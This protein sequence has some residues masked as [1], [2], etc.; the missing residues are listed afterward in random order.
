[1]QPVDER[2]QVEPRERRRAP[3]AAALHR[4]GRG[5]DGD[6]AEIDRVRPA[7]R[8]VGAR[9]HARL[10]RV[11]R[12]DRERQIGHLHARVGSLDARRQFER[13]KRRG[14]A[15]R[16]VEVGVQRRVELVVPCDQRAGEPRDEQEQRDGEPEPAMQ[17][18]EKRS[19]ERIH[20][21]RGDRKTGRHRR[22]PR[23]D[24]RKVI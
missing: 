12:L 1:M 3:F 20:R 8:R 7:G 18:D 23:V 17:A 21:V 10:Q 5:I 14:A 16:D 15:A 2:H 4:A 11:P 6:L 22:R 19:Q 9:Y 13:R 24:G